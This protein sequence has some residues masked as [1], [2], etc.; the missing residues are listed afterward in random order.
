MQARWVSRV[1]SGEF[2]LPSL[3]EMRDEHDKDWIVH[4][5][6]YIDR[7]RLLLKVDYLSYMDMI[8]SKIGCLPDIA[9]LWLNDWKLASQICF[10]PIISS[11]YRLSGPGSWSGARSLILK[12]A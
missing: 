6:N 2:S 5:E 4:C 8:A 7:E 12:S 11:Q 10:G 9:S 1:F 3:K